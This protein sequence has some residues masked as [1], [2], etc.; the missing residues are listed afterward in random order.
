MIR[1]IAAILISAA[2]VAVAALGWRGRLFDYPPVRYFWND[3]AVQ[4]RY[5]AQ[6]AS[7]FF[8]DGRVERTPVTGT[9]PWGYAA[10]RSDERFATSD[11]A[12]FAVATNPLPIDRALLARGRALYEL[13]CMV[14]HGAG[15]SGNGI[16]TQYG[17]NAPP[18]FHGDRLRDVT[19]GY[20]YQVITEGKNTMGPYGGRL[21]PDE[22][23]ATVAWV[24]VLQRA[25]AARIEDVPDAARRTL[26]AAP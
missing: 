14:C 10:E 9:V 8:A 4:P 22:R 16:T 12:R 15:G 18:T 24:R 21:S 23:W 11:A 17:M 7:P 5:N 25:H 20:V 13:N 1:I 3:M 2:L 19:D 26:E 6:E